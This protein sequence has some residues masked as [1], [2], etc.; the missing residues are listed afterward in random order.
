METAYHCA[1][2][3]ADPDRPAGRTLLLNSAH[4]SYVDLA[5]P[6]HL[7]FAYTQWIGAAAD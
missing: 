6:T 4:H 1:P 3:E 7:E 5:D 2:V